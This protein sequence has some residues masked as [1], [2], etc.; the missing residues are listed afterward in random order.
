MEQP[1]PMQLM[2]LREGVE[3]NDGPA[4]C[5][6]IDLITEQVGPINV[7]VVVA[8]LVEDNQVDTD[9]GHVISRARTAAWVVAP[10]ATHQVTPAEVAQITLLDGRRHQIE[11][12]RH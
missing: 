12:Q 11:D 10:T 5:C 2:Q 6:E 9:F 4:S 7:W 3:I 1:T 8:A